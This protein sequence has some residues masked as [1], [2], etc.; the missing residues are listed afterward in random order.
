MLI[1]PDFRRVKAKFKKSNNNK[2]NN[3]NKKL[4]TS[5]IPLLD[6]STLQKQKHKTLLQHR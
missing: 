4:N 5:T 2:H 6:S 3:N 1:T